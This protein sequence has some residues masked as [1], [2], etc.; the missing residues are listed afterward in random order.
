MTGIVVREGMYCWSTGEVA[1]LAFLPVPL[2]PY[3]FTVVCS[4]CALTYE[5]N[6]LPEEFS[7][8]KEAQER[9]SR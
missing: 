6:A 3:R 7:S 2:K 9:I 8:F 1:T 5:T 4:S